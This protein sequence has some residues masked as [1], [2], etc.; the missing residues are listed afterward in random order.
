MI[1]VLSEQAQCI[2]CC[3]KSAA[4]LRFFLTRPM[5]DNDCYPMR[6]FSVRFA[7]FF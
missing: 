1:R 6:I 5:F 2:L 3:F 4:L 7:G